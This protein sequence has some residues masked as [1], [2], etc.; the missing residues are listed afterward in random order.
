M[1]AFYW[2]FIIFLVAAYNEFARYAL[3]DA[4]GAGNRDDQSVGFFILS[5]LFLF[6]TFRKNISR[7]SIVVFILLL[8]FFAISNWWFYDFYRD[9]LTPGAVKLAIYAEETSMAWGGL[10]YKEEALYYVLSMIVLVSVLFSL[11]RYKPKKKTLYISSLVVFVLAV[12][13]QVVLSDIEKG[14]LKHRGVNHISYFIKG[15]VPRKRFEISKKHIGHIKASFPEKSIGISDPLFPLYQSV[16]K[17]LAGTHRN[18]NVIIIVMESV[19]MAET[20]LYDNPDPSVTPNL[21]KLGRQSLNFKSHYANSNQTVRG[22]VAILCSALDYINGGPYSLAGDA[23]RTN[24]L[25]SILS[26]YGY[27]TYW[28]HG[29]KKDFFNRENFFPKLGFKHLLDRDVINVNRDKHELGWGVSDSEVLD[30]AL[31]QLEKSEKPFFAEIMTLSNHYP[32]LW[33]WG[34]PF[35]DNLMA[36]DQ[37]VEDDNLYPAYKRGIYYTDHSLGQFFERFKNSKLYENTLLVVTADHGIWTFP[38]KL[39]NASDAPSE[40]Q[41]NEIYF[42][43]PLLIH[44]KDLKP[45]SI[46]KPASQVDI[47]P[48]I[49]D[50]LGIQYPNS[51]LGDS[52]LTR[53]ADGDYPVYFMASGSYGVRRDKQYCYP[54]DTSGLC[55]SYYRTCDSYTKSDAKTMCVSTSDDLL[56]SVDNLEVINVDT[57]SDDVFIN[58]SQQFLDYGFMPSNQILQ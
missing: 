12:Q 30:Y 23:M 40:L 36:T 11:D 29:Y 6:L 9:F 38:E 24:C 5:A 49:L 33:D 41:K 27:E 20:G 25:P 51:F 7:I 39:I 2:L 3:P 26:Q 35:P 42:R 10:K 22:E 47:T 58:L 52:L 55:S 32:Y 15:F 48:T 54:V 16:E 1:K 57:R 14:G 45:N 43:L 46:D 13:Q 53:K 31:E 56:L 19:R 34:I 8:S 44:A 17:T 21:D 18:K 37:L 50:Y 4:K 28:I